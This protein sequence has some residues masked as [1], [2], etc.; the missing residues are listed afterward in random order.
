M[1]RCTCWMQFPFSLA[2]WNSK[3]RP[4]DPVL[5]I[6]SSPKMYSYSA[7]RSFPNTGGSSVSAQTL[8]PDPFLRASPQ[9]PWVISPVGCGDRSYSH[10]LRRHPEV[11]NWATCEPRLRAFLRIVVEF[12]PRHADLRSRGR[13]DRLPSRAIAGAARTYGLVRGP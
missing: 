3:T 9:R 8:G 11:R 5:R 1:A 12:W 6:G 7:Y 13:S 2:H 4:P 10:S